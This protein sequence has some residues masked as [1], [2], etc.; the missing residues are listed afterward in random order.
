VHPG[1]GDAIL[2]AHK[3]G[4]HL[5]AADDRDVLLAGLRHL[6]IVGRDGGVGHH[7]LGAR[8]VFRPMPFR[9]LRA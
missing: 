8:H 3:L 2:Q 4:Q 7:D 5:G 9:D 6:G 1:D